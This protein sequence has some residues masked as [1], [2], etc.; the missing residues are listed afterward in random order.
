MLSVCCRGQVWAAS[1]PSRAA[2]EPSGVRAVRRPSRS[3]RR[4]SCAASVP[5]RAASEPCGERSVRRPSRADTV[6]FR[7]ATDPCGGPSRPV[8]WTVQR[9]NDV[10]RTRRMRA[11]KIL[12]GSAEIYI[13]EE[14][15]RVKFYKE[16]LKY[17]RRLR[18]S[19]ILEGS[20]DV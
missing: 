15:A 17:K 16:A 5:S 18:A 2:T 10:A 19:K 12:E 8:R 20:A 11:S 7:A 9:S 6:P 1:V 14:C 3:V 13:C 4:P